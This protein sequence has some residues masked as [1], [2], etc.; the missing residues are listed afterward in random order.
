MAL[1]GIN[2]RAA[3]FRVDET[4]LPACPSLPSNSTLQIG[5]IFGRYNISRTSS[6]LMKTSPHDRPEVAMRVKSRK[7]EAENLI[8]SFFSC[9]SRSVAVL[10]MVY[11]MRCGRCDVSASTLSIVWVH[12]FFGCAESGDKS[13]KVTTT[14]S[15]ASVAAQSSSDHQ[16]GQPSCDRL[17]V[18]YPQVVRMPV[19]VWRDVRNTSRITERWSKRCR[20]E[21]HRFMAGIICSAR[22]PMRQPVPP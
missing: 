21:L 1:S 11:A 17:D 2:D 16:T 14:S 13:F 22:G 18:R 6:L 4:A 7:P 12:P 5:Q 8:T 9:N 15:G 19:N 20:S 10:T 3:D